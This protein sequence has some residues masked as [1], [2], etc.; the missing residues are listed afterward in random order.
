[1]P[2][3]NGCYLVSVIFI[4]SIFLTTWEFW[5]KCRCKEEQALREL[6]RL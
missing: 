1:M 5:L 4:Q 3:H 2:P 6:L